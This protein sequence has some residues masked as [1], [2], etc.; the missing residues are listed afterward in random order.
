MMLQIVRL[1]L[2]PFETNT[3][4]IADEASGEAAVIDPAW[5]G[6]RIRAAA[7]ARGWRIAHLFYTHA[8]V[9]HIAGAAALADALNPLPIAALH[10]ADYKLWQASGGATWFGMQIDPGPDP[11]VG[12]THGQ[13]LRLGD[14]ALEVRHTPGHTPGHVVFYCAEAGVCF[15]GDLI[16]REGVGR[17]DLPGGDWSALERSIRAQIYTLPPETRLLPGHGPESTVGWEMGHNM[18]VCQ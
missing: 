4:L 8:H 17:T 10:P 18:F 3:Y 15:C 16:F 14:T 13:V 2:G 1:V 6:D 5:D 9:D 7:A 12:L 11:M